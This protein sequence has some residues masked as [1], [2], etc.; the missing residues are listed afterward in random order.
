MSS[1]KSLEP[2][3]MVLNTGS[4]IDI[5]EHKATQDAMRESEETFKHLFEESPSGLALVDT[6]GFIRKVNRA[7]LDMLGIS[8]EILIDKNFMDLVAAFGLHT[9]DYRTDFK[10]RL[11]DRNSNIE[12]TIPTLN[13][14][15]TTVSVQSSP[16]KTDGNI[17]NILYILTDITERKLTEEALLESER[18]Y[19][20][21]SENSSDVIWSID[22]NGKYQYV[23]PSVEKLRGFTVEEVMSQHIYQTLMPE[24]VEFVK[25]QMATLFQYLSQGTEIE[26]TQMFEM[27]QPCKDGSTVWV[28]VSIS[29]IWGKNGEPIGIQGV[30][31]DITERKNTEAALRESEERFRS[32]FENTTDGIIVS[33]TN[34]EFLYSNLAMS[35]MLGYTPEEL[36]A[37]K[38]EDIHPQKDLPAIMDIF[39][40]VVRNEIKTAHDLPMQRKDGSVF[41]VDINGNLIN[42]K[43]ETCMVG[44]FRDITECKKAE[45]ALKEREIKYRL[46][47]DTANEAIVVAQ[48]GML[49]FVNRKTIELLEGYTEQEIANTPFLAF[50]HPNDKEMVVENYKRRI[51]GEEVEERYSF[52]VITRAGAVKWVEISAV[53]IDWDGRPATLNFLSDITE[54]KKMEDALKD[55]LNDLGRYKRATVDRELRMVELKER[56]KQLEQKGGVS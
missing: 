6:Q 10:E 38:V 27:E 25:G 39:N 54:R 48:D 37:L 16:I 42:L 4:F 23:S 2:K 49:K 45:I 5:T 26:S 40:K 18:K 33:N 13:G 51:M 1:M 21:L 14:I 50:I 35:E 52:R 3:S 7:L 9:E 12:L 17:T 30:S 28:E 53:M 56:I 29:V 43:G 24:G 47:V 41:N 15:K 46:L 36:K 22:F 44:V 34:A 31:R 55:N 20:L 32:I 11:A 8:P 19:R